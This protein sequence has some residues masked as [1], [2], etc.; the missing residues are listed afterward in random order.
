MDRPGPPNPKSWSPS[1]HAFGDYLDIKCARGCRCPLFLVIRFCTESSEGLWVTPSLN[2]SSF[3]SHFNNIRVILE[4]LTG[5][6]ILATPP[7]RKSNYSGSGG[8]G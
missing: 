8:A 3:V 5:V 6:S 4:M 1:G 2:L 7:V